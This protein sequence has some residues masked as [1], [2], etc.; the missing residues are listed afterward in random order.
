MDIPILTRAKKH[1]RYPGRFRSD[2][3]WRPFSSLRAGHQLGLVISEQSLRLCLVKRFLQKSR[4]IDARTFQLGAE[5]SDEWLEKIGIAITIARRYLDERRISRVPVNVGLLG[6]DIGFRRMTLPHMPPKE[7]VSAIAWEGKNLFPF[8]FAKC[9]VHH[10]V[11]DRIIHD[12]GCR[13]GINVIAAREEIIRTV[14]EQLKSKNMKIGQVNFLPYFLT[15]ITPNGISVEEN[16][17]HLLLYLDSEQSMAVFIHDGY[18]DFFQEFVNQPNGGS[19]DNPATENISVI[20][21]E[22][23]SFLDIY[24]AHAR[25]KRIG[26]IIL[27]G[28]YGGNEQTVKEITSATGL[29]CRSIMSTGSL[30]AIGGNLSQWQLN[31]SIAAVMTALAP[32]WRRPLATPE[33]RRRLEK[34]KFIKRF[35][36]AATLALIT[37]AILLYTEYRNEKELTDRLNTVKHEISRIQKSDGYRTYLALIGELSRTRDY[38]QQAKSKKDSHYHVMLKELS[39]ILPEHLTLT[40]INLIEQ[41]GQY[42]LTLDGRV[43]LKRFSPEIILAQYVE[44]LEGSYFFQNVEVTAHSKRQ[45]KG[46]LDLSFQLRMDAQV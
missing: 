23:E 13:L 16:H 46:E 29:P 8:D 3:I 39:L 43:K 10:E 28:K 45:E 17:R 44:A 35:A 7:L 36:T 41:Q 12:D 11:A 4:I 21:D 34:T 38:M 2:L 31:E 40:S 20:I 22:L 5:D 30:R 25:E 18:L 26:S 42:I 14:F 6:P 15:R 37:V 24:N 19:Y 33:F 9:L 1:G 32:S 27:C